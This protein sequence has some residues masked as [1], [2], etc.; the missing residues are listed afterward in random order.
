M[1]KDAEED[2][3]VGEF[4][5]TGGSEVKGEDGTD[6]LPVPDV[7]PG[8]LVHAANTITDTNTKMTETRRLVP[9]GQLP[10]E[11]NRPIIG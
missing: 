8:S 9:A 4:V 1:G 7:A 2:S 11:G 6:G 5:G 3:C 10:I